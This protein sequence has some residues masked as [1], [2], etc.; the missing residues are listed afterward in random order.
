MMT[1]LIFGGN[2]QTRHSILKEQ[3]LF[4]HIQVV[5]NALGKIWVMTEHHI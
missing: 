1:S 5:K 4:Q 2:M 3:V